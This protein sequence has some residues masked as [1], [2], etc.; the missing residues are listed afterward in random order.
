MFGGLALMKADLEL[1]L[2]YAVEHPCVA[3]IPM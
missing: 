1:E 3:Q 2:L